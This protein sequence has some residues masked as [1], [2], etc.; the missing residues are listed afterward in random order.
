VKVEQMVF[1]L[2]EVATILG[3][4]RPTVYRLIASGALPTVKIWRAPRV[5]KAD[6]ERLLNGEPKAAA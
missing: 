1:S 3:I 5:R 4:S 2:S 6:I